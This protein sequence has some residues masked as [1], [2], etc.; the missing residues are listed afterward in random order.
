MT[1]MHA[2]YLAKA[3]KTPEKIAEKLILPLDERC[4][5][6]YLIAATR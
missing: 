5:V 3:E 4:K 1:E 2:L 6:W